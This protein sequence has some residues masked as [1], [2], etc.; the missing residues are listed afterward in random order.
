MGEEKQTSF[1]ISD[2]R[3]FNP[4]GTV[5][6]DAESSEESSLSPSSSAQASLPVSV[7]AENASFEVPPKEDLN[8]ADLS[9]LSVNFTEFVLGLAGNAMMC[10]GMVDTY[11]PME[12]DLPTAQHLIEVLE[13]LRRKTKNNLT[14]EE[15][16]ALND[17]LHN[18]Q[19]QYV[20]LTRSL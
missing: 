7:M 8:E 4:D 12:P 3:L 15:A 9:P 13:L 10:L 5:R 6:T 2:R 20:K 14:L 17:I 1:R 11:G 16:N 19:M 18:L